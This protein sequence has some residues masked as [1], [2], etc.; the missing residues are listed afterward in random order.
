[1][2]IVGTLAAVCLLLGSSA[3]W[4]QTV[5]VQ[6]GGPPPPP[7]PPRVVVTTPPPP[8]PPGYGPPPRV[9]IERPPFPR[10]RWGWSLEGGPYFFNGGTGGIGGATVRMGAQ[11]NELFGVYAQAA[12]FGGGGGNISSA[13]GASVEVIA[14]ASLGV[15]A[16]LDLGNVFYIAA[17]PEIMAG[18]AGADSAGPGGAS[19]SES[20]GAFFSLTGRLGVVL[21]RV[22]PMRRKGFQLGLDFHTII[23]PGGVVITPMLALGLEAF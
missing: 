2:K 14:A 1:M 22:T 12:G 10:F 21:G 6:V 23:T 17:G 16:E 19:V 20:V 7:P 18:E 11:I 3:A 13:S 15:L 5:D 8:P 9:M 4:A